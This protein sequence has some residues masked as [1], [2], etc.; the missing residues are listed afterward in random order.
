[1]RRLGPRRRFPLLAVNISTWFIDLLNY[2]FG[3]H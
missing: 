3:F 2:S 1:M